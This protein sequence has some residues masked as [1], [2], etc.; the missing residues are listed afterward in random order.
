MGL[1]CAYAP[2]A[3]AQYQALHFDETALPPE[4]QQA[5]NIVSYGSIFANIA[6]HNASIPIGFSPTP[7]ISASAEFAGI[8]ADNALKFTKAALN[9]PPNVT[10]SPNVAGNCSYRFELPQA[11]AEF[12]NF[13]GLWPKLGDDALLRSRDTPISFGVLGVPQIL[14][15]HT[16]VALSVFGPTAGIANDGDGTAVDEEAPQTVL[17]PAGAHAIEWR[18]DTLW[19]PVWDAVVPTALAAVMAAM[20]FKFADNVAA[21]TAQK[22]DALELASIKSNPGKLTAQLDHIDNALHLYERL[23]WRLFGADV[24]F[25]VSEPVTSEL[26]VE[27]FFEPTKTV[28]RSRLQTLTVYDVLPPTI[29][30]SD[31]AP[32]KEA[33][34]IGGARTAR[35]LPDL[36][37]LI[38]ASD[39]C[40]RPVTVTNDAPDFLPLGS[41]LVTWTVRDPGPSAPGVDHDGDGVVDTQAFN[42][43]TVTQLVT[44]KDTQAPIMVPPPGVVIESNASVDLANQ[45]LGQPL[46]VD[47]A[48]LHPT[49]T[50][51]S[52]SVD[53]IVPP[54]TRTVVT[55]SAADD[56]TPPNVTTAQQLVTVKTPG[57]NTAP[58]ASPAS[59]DTLTSKAVPIVLTGFDADVLPLTADPAGAGIRDPLQFKI[60]SL[61]QHGELVAP[62]YPFFIDDY[63]TDKVGGLIAYIES[64][65]DAA[66][67]R[68]SYETAVATRNLENWLNVEFC[69]ASP[70]QPAPVDFVFEPRYVQ[71]TD[72]GE[73]Y[74][75]DNYLVCDPNPDEDWALR[76][77]I[78]RW[79]A[80]GEFLGHVRIDDNG[81]GGI[82]PEEAAFRF[83]DDGFLYFVAKNTGGE[84]VVSVHRCSSQLT[85]TSN[86][87]ATCGQ[88]SGNYFGPIDANRHSGQSDP[89]NAFLDSD[90]GIAY[91]TDGHRID[92]YRLAF[93]YQNVGTLVND[94]GVADLFGVAACRTSGSPD[95]DDEMEI[96][97]E[98]NLYVI[99]NDCNRIHKFTPSYFDDDGAF[100]LGDYVGWMGRCNGS[101]NLACD[102]PNQRTKGY[103]CTAASACTA[104]SGDSDG[105]LI[106]QFANPAFL[107]M[108][109]ND[110]LYVADYG[111]SRIQRFGPDGTF[112][113]QAQSTGNG[114]NAPVDGAFVL[115]NMGP[116]K[117]VSV[118]SRR[119]YVVDQQERFVHVFDASPFTDVTA[120]T[121]TVNYVSD[122]DF[123]TSTDTFSYSVHDGLVSSNVAQVS[124]AVARNYRQPQPT[125]Q[126]VA[127]TEDHSV[128]IVLSGTDPDGIVSRDFNG[129]DSLTFV[130]DR[131]PR[132][133][134]LARGGA[135]P[136]GVTLDPGNEVWT[137]TPNRDFAGS[138]VFSFTVRDAFTDE[139][140]DGPREIPE[141]YG[142]AEP[143]DVAVAVAS[144][145]D[146]PIVRLDRPQRVAAG[147]P[148]LLQ[149]SVYDDLGEDHAATVIWGDGRAERNG[150]AVIDDNGTPNDTS[151]DEARMTGVVLSAEALEAVG[152]SPVVASHTYAQPGPRKI[153]LCL[154]DAGRLEACGAVDIT[155]ES[156]VAMGARISLSDDEVAD[157]VPFDATIDVVNGAPSI[158]VAGLAA[159]N[160]TVTLQVPP[161]L[162]ASAYSPSQGSCAVDDGRLQCALGTLANGA[163]ASVNLRLRGRGTLM[164]SRGLSL[165]AEVRTTTDALVDAALGSASIDLKAVMLDRDGDG[166]TNLF[167]GFYG[168]DDPLADADAD[169][170]TNL[171]ELDHGT[172][173]VAADTDGDGVADGAEVNTHA[174][175]PFAMDSDGDGLADGV[176]VG[177]HHTSPSDADSDG[178]GLPDDF[179]VANGFDPRVADSD[180]DRDGDGLSDADEH[181]NGTDLLAADTDGDTL[182]DAE[183]VNVYGTDPTQADTDED[184]LAD[185]L[186]LVAGTDS[187]KPDSDDDGLLDGAE[188]AAGTSPLDADFDDDGLPDGWEARNGRNP[189]VADVTSD[190]DGD[191]V[192]TAA[193]LAN[194]TDPLDRDT[195]RD[196]LADN[197]ELSGGTNPREADTDGDG[198]VDGDEVAVHHSNPLLADGDADGLPDDWEV[199]HG[200]APLVNDAAAD[201]DADGLVNRSEYK[202][203]SDPN[204]ADTDG[205][206]VSD[207]T[208][209][210]TLRYRNSGQALGTAIGEAVALG[211]LDGDDDL[212]AFVAN[213]VGGSEIWLNDGD[214]TYTLD[215][216]NALNDAEALDVDLADVDGDGD[217]DAVLAHP[218]QPNSLWINGAGGNAE[219]IFTLSAE[220]VGTGVSDGVEFGTRFRSAH[221]GPS[222]AVANWG[223]NEA[224]AFD[225]GVRVAVTV[226]DPLRGNSEDVAVGDLNRDGLDDAFVV[227]RNGANQVFF[228]SDVGICFSGLCDSGQRLGTGA[229]SIAVALGDVDGDGDFDLIVG[230]YSHWTPT[231][232]VLN[233]EEKARVAEL[234]RIIDE[235]DKKLDAWN[236]ELSKLLAALPAEER[237]K[238]YPELYA[239]KKDER[240]AIM[241]ERT[242]ALEEREKLAPGPKRI[243]YVW[244]YENKTA[245]AKSN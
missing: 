173:P 135:A 136:P 213:R 148:V 187:L 141:P 164:K 84:P 96:D 45:A 108:D 197:I 8:A 176:E 54:D 149:G 153:T 53:G 111:N 190:P 11:T 142:Q 223:A 240:A 104:P 110:V 157:G 230:G 214:G 129:L 95:F 161:E 12:Q 152:Q 32:T 234:T 206:G 172:S 154:R 199:E 170:L 106:G 241:K 117:H 182:S 122:F 47:L 133:G 85:D 23:D 62:L 233:D 168:V 166:L 6:V 7:L 219:G 218:T 50:R 2:L 143:V 14:H 21:L 211:D 174:S 231:P 163:K 107:A 115:G 29:T 24:F 60:E 77:R 39:A 131:E 74:F 44:I 126:T 184:G 100:V 162:V 178:D 138:D 103:S 70:N 147:F 31:A 34:D 28:S 114:I 59:A 90:R 183:E 68:Q 209:L 165:D 245:A 150:D 94:A 220:T 43:R 63:R 1:G 158:G 25:T 196:G 140:S 144:V 181:A 67:L 124:V 102:V 242:P 188:A 226:S 180:G 171:A 87:P 203:N 64:Q 42:S 205:D 125:G 46:V 159:E 27:R 156:L 123:H 99:D 128:A 145:N 244:L 201:P 177:V 120:S 175:D 207:R 194:G 160:V 78:S 86:Q 204:N 52:D 185:Q 232:P 81:G 134:T 66:T 116:P 83:S 216:A 119:F 26:I 238:K 151:D 36:S 4:Q 193:E 75:F 3:A 243:S 10:V 198:L 221:S 229:E 195:D 222:L 19:Y 137:Y 105:A 18:A 224:F 217:L 22:S 56:G 88:S 191:G 37:S 169:G 186:E 121:A 93:P 69:D 35:Y 61:P 76:P 146:I 20:E 189:L 5:L 200:L 112:A 89:E 113:G 98:G 73:Q 208:E 225:D 71:V 55:W 72:A 38:T 9:A 41:T 30:T 15:A 49:V 155:V 57:T 212:D 210:A 109:P 58:T 167:E 16:D 179:E 92:V 51:S 118:N 239:S 192:P 237:E 236:K 79:S 40:G 97:S 80:A 91:V 132:H 130:I 82:R 227:N 127:T 13:L 48:D 228:G 215:T 33:T 235:A 101:N 202:Y 65:P 139:T 17:V